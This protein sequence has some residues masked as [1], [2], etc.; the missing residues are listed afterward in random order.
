MPV[1]ESHANDT[2]SSSLISGL[3]QFAIASLT[4]PNAETSS[5]VI[6]LKDK[7]TLEG[8]KKDLEEAKIEF[9]EAKSKLEIAALKAEGTRQFASH[10]P[11]AAA[12]AVLPAALWAKG[13]T[14]DHFPSLEQWKQAELVVQLQDDEISKLKLQQEEAKA[15]LEAKKQEL[16]H[17]LDRVTQL[18]QE[19]SSLE[20][21]LQVAEQ[22]N[23]DARPERV[24]AAVQT[25]EEPIEGINWAFL[26]VAT[27]VAFACY[28]GSQFGDN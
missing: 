3:A 10:L 16:E 5:G 26:G 7:N 8:E 6:I 13:N 19:K 17:A 28:M 14:E 20:A 27:S 12:A 18:N 4:S 25:L 15:A 21:A 9:Q 22:Q 24:E 2:A 23:A 1:K 11:V